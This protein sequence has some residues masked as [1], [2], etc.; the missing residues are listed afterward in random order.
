VF[1]DGESFTLELPKVS[2]ITERP[3]NLGSLVSP[4]PGKIIQVSV[5]PGDH[6]QKGQTLVIMEA[7]KMEHTIRAPTA[8]VVKKVLSKPGDKIGKDVL[9]VEVD[10]V[11]EK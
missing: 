3:T 4:M 5:K 7:M 10:P 2:F 9:L 11:E 1:V 8:G 6:V